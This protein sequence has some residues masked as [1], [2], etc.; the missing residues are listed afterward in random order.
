[1]TPLSTIHVRRTAAAFLLAAT[2]SVAAPAAQSQSY[3]NLSDLP[4]SVATPLPC[5]KGYGDECPTRVRLKREVVVWGVP[6]KAGTVAQ[7]WEEDRN[8]VLARDTLYKGAWLKGGT[9]VHFY[10]TWGGTLLRDQVLDGVPCRGN[11]EIA[12][13]TETGHV[14]ECTLGAPHTAAGIELA[15][16]S[17]LT[18]GPNG[19][20]SAAKLT[21]DHRIEGRRYSAGLTL[22]FDGNERLTDV[23]KVP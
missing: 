4:R 6:L 9:K 18:F 16:G 10:S 17:K 22:F 11:T 19:K 21:A 14:T 8:G 23:V 20:L 12:F 3:E 15:P 5:P 13:D 2:L 1:M 7:D